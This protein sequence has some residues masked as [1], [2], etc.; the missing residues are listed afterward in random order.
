VRHMVLIEGLELWTPKHHLMSHINQRAG[1][2]GNPWR[3]TT[4]LDESLNKDLKQ[5]LRLCHPCNFEAMA[6]VKVEAVLAR[7]QKRYRPC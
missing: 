7:G 4:F 1:F 2:H 3:Y 6:F 5:C